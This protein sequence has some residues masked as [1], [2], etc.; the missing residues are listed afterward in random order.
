MFGAPEEWQRG[1][2]P[3]EDSVNALVP[4]FGRVVGTLVKNVKADVR[5][6]MRDRVGTR[7]SAGMLSSCAAPAAR[8]EHP[9]QPM[10]LGCVGEV[11]LRCVEMYDLVL[12]E[13]TL[14]RCSVDL[15]GDHHVGRV[16]PAH[17]QLINH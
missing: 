7:P 14:N 9:H 4:P 16:H 13:A 2:D 6:T 15:L 3:R 5:H 17:K 12:L 11:E 10:R 1:Y 8:L